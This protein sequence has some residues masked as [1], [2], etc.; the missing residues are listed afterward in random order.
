MY[1]RHELEIV[2]LH[3]TG[4]QK[5]K[6]YECKKCGF[7]HVVNLNRIADMNYLHEEI[8]KDLLECTE[9]L[10][11]SEIEDIAK[12]YF[13][14]KIKNRYFKVSVDEIENEKEV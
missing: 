8:V 11:D 12:E 9:T 1:C 3:F 13:K 10:Y 4:S 7:E 14:V 5:H 2:N 6:V